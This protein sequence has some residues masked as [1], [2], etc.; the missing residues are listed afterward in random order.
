MPRQP[1]CKCESARGCVDRGRSAGAAIIAELTAILPSWSAEQ[2]IEVAPAVLK[3]REQSMP[4]QPECK[5]EPCQR[6]RAMNMRWHNKPEVKERRLRETATRARE[7]RATA[8]R[9]ASLK[10]CRICGVDITESCLYNRLCPSCQADLGPLPIPRPPKRVEPT[11]EQLDAQ[12]LA[13]LEQ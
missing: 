7:K 1:E 2:I 9:G 6:R 3:K 5:C 12:A 4:R 11:D 10:F 8:K 13:S